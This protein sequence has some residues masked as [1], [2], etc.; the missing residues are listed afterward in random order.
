MKQIQ[1][2]IPTPCHEDWHAMLPEEK[3]R[4]CLSCQKT[5]VD[6]SMMSDAEI[7]KQIADSS[8][9]LCG[10]FSPDQLD[11][12]ITTLP[13][14]K[15]NVFRYAWNMAAAFLIF[16]TKSSAQVKPAKDTIV[17]A[18]LKKV[19]DERL[20]RGEISTTVINNKHIIKGR[21]TDTTG[22]PI[23][24]ASVWIK[25]TKQGVTTDEQGNFSISTYAASYPVTLIISYIGYSVT[26]KLI[27]EE[28]Y[29]KPVLIQLKQQFTGWLGGAVVVTVKKKKKL[30][31]I[32]KKKETP[33]CVK[34]VVEPKLS[35]FPNPAPV[36]QEVKMQLKDLAL[37]QWQMNLYNSAGK[38][39]L[40]DPITILSADQTSTIPAIYTKMAG[41]YV[42]ELTNASLNRKVTGKLLVQ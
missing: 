20:M 23:A 13:Q 42:I 29:D 11:R 16:S 31:N 1:I 5:V 37:G 18:P 15:T 41:L 17:W 28:Q 14:R 35:I 8:K 7:L 3:G 19:D 40:T 21:V 30:L 32:F 4:F 6:F 9:N 38:L 22:N 10:N 27:T 26:E 36:L 12:Q 24:F 25:T 39:L 2:S 33:V 34:P